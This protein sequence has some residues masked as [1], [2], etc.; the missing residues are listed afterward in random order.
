MEIMLST[1]LQPQHSNRWLLS[2]NG[3]H[4]DKWIYRQRVSSL[5]FH[6]LHLLHVLHSQ[7]W[8]QVIF[9]QLNSIVPKKHNQH[10]SIYNFFFLSLNIC[11]FTTSNPHYKPICLRPEVRIWGLGKRV[12]SVYSI[13]HMINNLV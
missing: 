9:Y 6:F 1:S 4:A 10:L 2:L 13:S 5:I 3:T 12:K 7:I 8:N 11:N